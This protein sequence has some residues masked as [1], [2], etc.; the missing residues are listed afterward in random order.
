M[1]RDIPLEPA[2]QTLASLAMV[3]DFEPAFTDWFTLD[4]NLVGLA[5]SGHLVFPQPALVAFGSEVTT[6]LLA[7][8]TLAALDTMA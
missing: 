5:Y 6:L 1:A 4:E 7:E 8:Q 3:L 2:R